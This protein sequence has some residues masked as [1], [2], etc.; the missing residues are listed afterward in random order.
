MHYFVYVAIN[1]IAISQ[2]FL[3]PLTA[4]NEILNFYA[5]ST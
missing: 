1:Y 5:E 4:E 2:Q 3:N